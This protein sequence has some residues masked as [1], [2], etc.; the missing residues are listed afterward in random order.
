[1]IYIKQEAQ[2]PL[3]S[4][5]KQF[6]SRKFVP[7][8]NEIGPMVMEKNYITV[9]LLFY[10]YLP[11]KKGRAL[12]LNKPESKSPKDALC[13]FWLKLAQDSGSVVLEKKTNK[14]FTTTLTTTTTDRKI[15]IRKLT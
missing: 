6:E 4:P 1:M 2:G 5:E 7:S 9:F 8:L 3:C 13:Q 12:H 14:K 11:S 10:Y 15:V